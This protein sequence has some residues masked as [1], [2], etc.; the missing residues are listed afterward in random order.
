[1][2]RSRSYP[3]LPSDIRRLNRGL[4]SPAEPVAELGRLRAPYPASRPWDRQ[5][6]GRWFDS[7]PDPAYRTSGTSTPVIVA[8]G[9]SKKVLVAWSSHAAE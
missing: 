6:Q 9:G 7:K 3:R 2:G 5:S 1:M 8:Y 4:K